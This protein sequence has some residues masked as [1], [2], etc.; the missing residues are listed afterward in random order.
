MLIF[1]IDDEPKMLALLH[2]AIAEAEPDAEIMDF[3]DGGEV[4]SAIQERD[5]TPDVVTDILGGDVGISAEM[6][7]KALD[8]EHF[9][10]IRTITGGPGHPEV[11]RMI[12]ARV[13]R[14]SQWAADRQAFDRQLECAH[15]GLEKALASYR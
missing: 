14:M 3:A 10:S 8:A 15:S 12:E 9:V 2:D 1:A 4:I 7:A 11:D 6:I 13:E 5:L